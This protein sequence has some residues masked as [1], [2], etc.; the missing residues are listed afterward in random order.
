M[1]N[2]N[3]KLIIY[4]IG[5]SMIVLL[6][7]VYI[8]VCAI[9]YGAL[10]S[11]Y[12]GD[13]LHSLRGQLLLSCILLAVLLQ[14]KNK[15]LGSVALVISGLLIT[16]HYFYSL[17]FDTEVKNDVLSVKQINLR[18]TNNN[19]IEHFTDFNS[20]DRDLFILLEFS[21][22]NRAQFAKIK[23]LFS[24]YGYKE[25]EGFPM[26][27][28]VISR[29]PIVYRQFVQVDGPKVGYVHLKIL[30]T[31]RIVD[32]VVFH[33]PSP[34]NEKLWKQRNKLLTEVGALLKELG[35]LWVMAGDFNTVF[36]SRYL[37]TT[38]GKWCYSTKGYH[39]TWRSVESI[40]AIIGG[41]A[42]DHCAVS[43]EININEFDVFPFTGSDHSVLTYKLSF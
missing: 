30:V 32:I 41:L 8:A 14:I 23:P 27:V 10:D 35:S 17:G 26:G 11:F 12:V 36:W 38:L 25:I 18:Y 16:S 39:T 3:L 7:S 4:H 24:R 2:F 37:N 20:D 6:C 21:D 19:L 1:H 33:P 9:A 43:R 22:K 28:A 42:I 13:L 40:P 15:Y 31:D 29:Y 5:G 34:R